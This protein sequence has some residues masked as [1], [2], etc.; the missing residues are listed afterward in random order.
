MAASAD[1]INAAT[2]RLDS[3]ME[4][5]DARMRAAITNVFQQARLGMALGTITKL[6]ASMAE[7]GTEGE[8]GEVLSAD[9]SLG[10]LSEAMT[11][12]IMAEMM[13]L[14]NRSF[15]SGAID[16]IIHMPNA[17]AMYTLDPKTGVPARVLNPLAEA[18]LANSEIAI[19]GASQG[20]MSK[21]QASLTAGFAKGE[22][23]P[24]LANRVMQAGVDSL[25]GAT[26]IARTQVVQAS[27]AGSMAQARLFAPYGQVTKEW[28][29]TS[30]RRTRASHV[31]AGGQEVGLDEK[32]VVGGWHLDFPGD[33]TGPPSEVRN[34]RCTVLF[35]EAPITD[36]LPPPEPNAVP[37]TL[38]SDLPEERVEGMTLEERQQ[39]VVENLD[40][41]IGK[42]FTTRLISNNGG[43]VRDF[44]QS[45]LEVEDWLKQNG[46]TKL[47]DKDIVPEQVINL[48]NAR[49]NIRSQ[50]A[51]E[52]IHPD[53]RTFFAEQNKSASFLERRNQGDLGG[54]ERY[55]SDL[56]AKGDDMSI[57]NFR[58]ASHYY[59]FVV[60]DQELTDLWTKQLSW[61]RGHSSD[62]E[63]HGGDLTQGFRQF[64]TWADQDEWY[65]EHFGASWEK[66]RKTTIKKW[67]TSTKGDNDMM[68]NAYKRGLTEDEFNAMVEET[69][70]AL[71][72][73]EQA[74]FKAG[75]YKDVQAMAAKM[76]RIME[77]SVLPEDTILWRGIARN[78]DAGADNSLFSAMDSYIE[79]HGDLR[80]FEFADK[81]YQSTSVDPQ[82]TAMFSSGNA[83]TAGGALWNERDISQVG[84]PN[85]V[86]RI[87]APEGTHA[88]PVWRAATS[89]DFEREVL[90]A[91]CTTFRVV[92]HDIMG[93]RHNQAHRVTVE[94][95]QG[96][97]PP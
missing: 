71:P 78:T 79:E 81:A 54:F 13:P 86:M 58:G 69:R 77:D 74:G 19:K 2:D 6:V 66:G 11:D 96:E 16:A 1:R 80:G 59:G 22:P 50:M 43:D 60:D 23:I 17:A 10:N 33:P 92:S 72:S 85:L 30:D 45:D 97:C 41:Y 84:R 57:D 15:D 73:Y 47:Y 36:V 27:N 70:A 35:E 25:P 76:D 8:L 52:S 83:G 4:E 34:C 12:S 14:M 91:S 29:N 5:A 32:F 7:F 88:A 39:W 90:L 67:L 40:D 44:I 48:R 75:S 62:L 26:S 82:G 21:V 9:I 93:L 31:K 95:I 24:K 64:S 3:L 63:I 38:P 46:I 89:Y 42:D 28:L 55:L 87:L 53:I 51:A 94:L 49:N 68:V 56:I 61:S 20:V 37:Q 18:H 65:D